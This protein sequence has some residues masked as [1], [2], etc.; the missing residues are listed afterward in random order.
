MSKP[1]VIDGP[2]QWAWPLGGRPIDGDGGSVLIG[3]E[4]DMRPERGD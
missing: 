3:G 2:E 4:F 1:I